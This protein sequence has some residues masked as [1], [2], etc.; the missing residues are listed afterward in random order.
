MN[1]GNDHEISITELAKLIVKRSGSQS[2][3]QYQTYQEAYGLEFEDITHRRPDLDKLRNLTG[4]KNQWTL[5]QAIDLLIE[6]ERM[7]P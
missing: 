4:F 3:L 2:E 1:V 5:E 7:K 6:Q